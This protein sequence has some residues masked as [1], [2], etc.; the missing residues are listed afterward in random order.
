MTCIHYNTKP[1]KHE[2]TNL[3]PA[4]AAA[5]SSQGGLKHLGL[6]LAG[7]PEELR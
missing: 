3:L 2:A 6:G 1:L 4:Q 5:R 7:G